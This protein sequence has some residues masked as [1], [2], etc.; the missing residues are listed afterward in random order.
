MLKCDCFFLDQFNFSYWT[1][2][3]QQ[4]QQQLREIS[5]L[6]VGLFLWSAGS[7]MNQEV[8]IAAP[9]SWFWLQVRSSVQVSCLC[10]VPEISVSFSYKW[11]TFL[12]Y[13]S[14]SNCDI[15]R[16]PNYLINL[17]CS[18]RA[19]TRAKKEN[20]IVLSTKKKFCQWGKKM[21]LVISSHRV[22]KVETVSCWCDF[23]AMGHYLASVWGDRRAI[24]WV[25]KWLQRVDRGPEPPSVP[26][27]EGSNAREQPGRYY[28]SGIGTGV[29]SLPAIDPDHNQSGNHW[30][31]QS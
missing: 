3:K 29:Q 21:S 1:L 5:W 27:E 14:V 17:S 19:K 31:A 12:W 10:R 25:R 6:I 30:A 4:Q 22:I 7:R 8:N 20:V 28:R 9:L 18:S 26:D 2:Q 16:K 23:L 15:N 11:S 13:I 24:D